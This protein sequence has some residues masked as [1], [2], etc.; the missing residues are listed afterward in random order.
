MITKFEKKASHWF[1]E[2]V[3]SNPLIYN[4]LHFGQYSR[5]VIVLNIFRFSAK[6]SKTNS[7]F[8]KSFLSVCGTRWDE[9]IDV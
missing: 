7:K 4:T 9:S 5:I 6:N 8:W 2:L 1:V 3:E